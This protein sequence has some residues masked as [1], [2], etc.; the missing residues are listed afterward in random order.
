[1]ADLIAINK[2]DD[3]HVLESQRTASELADALKYFEPLDPDWKPPVMTCSAR[4]GT[5]VD[6]VLLQVE[7]HKAHLIESGSLGDKRIRQQTQ[8]M[9]A[10]VRDRLLNRLRND[11][12]IRRRV[13]SLQNQMR[14]GETTATRG[15][16]ELLTELERS[17]VKQ[18]N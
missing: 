16:E 1:L 5:G 2:A 9:L 11:P 12:S 14:R 17:V 15:A 18:C 8:W 10:L 3:S 6:G 4:D 7:L 13:R